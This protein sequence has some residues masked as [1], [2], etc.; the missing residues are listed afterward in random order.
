MWRDEKSYDQKFF[1]DRSAGS[2]RSARH[3]IPIVLKTFTVSSVIDVGCGIGTWLCEFA[4]LGVQNYLGI[5]GNYIDRDQLLISHDY[6]RSADLAQRF[7]VGRFDLACSLEV[8]EHLP[9]S[10]ADS[11][12][13]SLTKSAPV[14]LFSAAIPHQGGVHHVNEQWQSYWAKKF[15]AHGYVAL[16]FIRPLVRHNKDVQVWYRQNTLVYC[17][18]EMRPVNIPPIPSISDLDE[19][20]PEFYESRMTQIPGG[21]QSVR[22]LKHAILRRIGL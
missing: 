12:V 21:R 8:A 1:D 4:R 2:S 22:G 16:D 14:V 10:S 7:S 17:D 5:D 3:I 19:V 13:E 15:A 6:F 11:F 9:E 18:P 20:L